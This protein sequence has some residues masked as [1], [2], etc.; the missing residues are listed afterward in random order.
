MRFLMRLIL[1]GLVLL[2]MGVAWLGAQQ[3]HDGGDTQKESNAGKI[4]WQ[5]DTGG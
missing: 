1:A 3:P 4:T 2:C 5:Y